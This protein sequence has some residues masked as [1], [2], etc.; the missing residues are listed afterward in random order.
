MREER[1]ASL[2]EDLEEITAAY[3]HRQLSSLE[4]VIRYLLGERRVEDLLMLLEVPVNSDLDVAQ[5]SAQSSSDED[6]DELK[7]HDMD[8]S[9]WTLET[10]NAAY[11]IP[12]PKAC[13]AL[14]SNDGRLV[15]F[16]P[17]KEEN[18]HSILDTFSIQ[19]SEHSLRSQTSIFENFGHLSKLYNQRRRSSSG[20]E[21]SSDYDAASSSESSS[22]SEV[23]DVRNR[24]FLPS[25]ALGDSNF[26]KRHDVALVE[27]QYS[28]GAPLEQNPDPSPN[29]VC[30][31]DL[32][33]LLPSKKVLA[34][35]YILS[36]DRQSCCDH[37]ANVA[38]AAG[39]QELAD[40]WSLVA[41]ICQR[42]VPPSAISQSQGKEPSRAIA[43][44][45]DTHP[46]RSRDS[47]IDL[48]FD[49]AELTSEKSISNNVGRNQHSFWHLW[50]A[51][52]LMLHFEK[53]ADV[54]MLAMLSCVLSRQQGEDR[55]V[56]SDESEAQSNMPGSV[57]KES[58]ATYP[59][60][61]R[62][63][64]DYT[65]IGSFPTTL[66]GKT[67]VGPVISEFV[68]SASDRRRQLSNTTTPSISFRHSRSNSDYQESQNLS[69]STS[70]EQLRQAPRS[71]SNLATNFAASLSRQFSFSTSTSSSPPTRKG[72][73]PSEGYLGTAHAAIAVG[74]TK[75][76]GQYST[77]PEAPRTPYSL[78]T[79]DT[80]EEASV[81]KP[82][83]RIALK[84]EGC[85]DI[86][87]HTTNPAYHHSQDRKADAY[88]HAY[89]EMLLAWN[90]PLEMC[91]V[92]KH[93]GDA[94]GCHDNKA[95]ALLD[96]KFRKPSS[97]RD[98]DLMGLEF[99]DACLKCGSIPRG[100]NTS[101]FCFQCSARKPPMVCLFCESLVN[102]LASACL[103]CGHVLHVSCRA[104]LE[105]QSFA[106]DEP[107]D[108]RYTCVSGC[109][110]Q[111]SDHVSVEVPGS[112]ESVENDSEVLSTLAQSGPGEVE[113]EARGGW[114][115]VAYESLA[116]NLGGRHLTPKTSQIWRGGDGE[117]GQNRK[118]SVGSNLR[119][120]DVSGL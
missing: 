59:A 27:S 88:R 1:A 98:N 90:L 29:Y 35:H 39:Y 64:I 67:A 41:L 107:D 3:C 34:Q 65:Q 112:P 58:L 68:R 53:S 70:P 86:E 89:G 99:I 119:Y 66:D 79:S 92:L 23:T 11:N 40:V 12:L 47:A 20:G 82:V 117:A 110:C 45:R 87:R 91:E 49:S 18:V 30:V 19:A 102:G 24:L 80:E 97:S 28:A 93:T 55:T 5:R 78:P 113:K 69:L 32:Q 44:R 105:G 17:R 31:H 114:Q 50:V 81:H 33:D 26:V 111:C 101:Q 2:L 62:S 95:S 83:F 60:S 21:S 42:N 8:T 54:Q 116:R 15:C 51:N 72:L 43:A 71:N 76:S 36:E 63:T 94:Q 96:L 109:G 115:D 14:W 25:I 57:H 100:R 104:M 13:G 52:E 74:N 118:K 38:E 103:S 106:W 73:S 108:E 16:F 61:E 22:S 77:P 56:N 6:E 10:S 4:A 48:S 75:P 46:L 37:N 9:P 7:A 84:N 120:E 85:F